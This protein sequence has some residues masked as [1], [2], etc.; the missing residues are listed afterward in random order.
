MSRQP[1]CTLPRVAL[2][3]SFVSVPVFGE[4][5]RTPWGDPD[6][7]GTWVNNSATPLERPD[8]FQG[9]ETFTDEELQ[10]LYLTLPD[11]RKLFMGSSGTGAPKDGADP[12]EKKQGKLKS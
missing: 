11:G 12:T 3:L 4:T 6:L 8:A 10:E 5:P 2:V 1:C 9:K 7:Q